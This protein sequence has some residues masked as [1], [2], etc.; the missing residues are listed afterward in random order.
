MMARVRYIY[1]PPS[2]TYCVDRQTPDSACTAS[3]LYSGI[4][5]N[6][7]TLGY[8]SG[9][10]Q[11]NDSS[12]TASNEVTTILKWAQDS[13]KATGFVT[14]ARVTHATPAALYAHTVDRDYE[15]DSEMPNNSKAKDI[16]W[17]LIHADPGNK[18]NVMLGG[19][20]PAF[21]P[22]IARK[23]LFWPKVA[24]KCQIDLKKLP[25]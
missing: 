10:E 23:V 11:D 3:A 14:T 22:R 18:I 17:Q 7:G 5:T 15:C 16:A 24:K 1:F 8:D 6:Y 20:G 9:V 4:K 2:Q 13:G 19:G 12:V 25:F 21:F